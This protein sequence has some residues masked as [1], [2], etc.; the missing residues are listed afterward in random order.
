M[1]NHEEYDFTFYADTESDTVKF[2]NEAVSDFCDKHIGYPDAVFLQ[3]WRRVTTLPSDMWTSIKIGVVPIAVKSPQ[4]N[5]IPVFLDNL[6]LRPDTALCIRKKAI[7]PNNAVPP[8][9]TLGDS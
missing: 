3:C 6:P 7:P 1:L 4:D 9:P 8:V 2:I 5:D